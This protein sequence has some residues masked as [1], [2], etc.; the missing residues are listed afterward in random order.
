VRVLVG[1]VP[2]GVVAVVLGL[3]SLALAAFPGAN[4]LLAVQPRGGGGIVLVGANGRG[5]RRI[6]VAQA[7]CGTLARSRWSPD[8]R[9][10]VFAGPGIR[11]VYPDGSCLNCQF[12]AAGN[13]V[14]ERGGTVISFIHNGKVT[15]DGIDGIRQPSPPPGAA[16]E[17][18]WSAGGLVAVVRHGAIWAGRPNHLMKIGIGTEPSWSPRGT[19]IAVSSEAGS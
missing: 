10:L 17:A 12:G 16:T 5:E 11:I 18:T 6:C 13:P 8:G 15:L 9:A 19:V 7:R 3:A 1:L 4:G 2:E 14:F